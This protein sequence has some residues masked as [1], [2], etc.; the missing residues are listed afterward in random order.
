MYLFALGRPFF[1]YYAAVY[2]TAASPPTVLE[3]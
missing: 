1:Y 2:D 3:K